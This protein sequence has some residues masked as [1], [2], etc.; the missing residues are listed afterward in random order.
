MSEPTRL[1]DK[2]RNS[3]EILQIL[4]A[5]SVPRRMTHSELDRA[6]ARVA[7]FIGGP[8]AAIGFLFWAKK[9][10][11]AAMIGIG[12]G[13]VVVAVT[14]VLRHHVDAPAT[15]APPR[16]AEVPPLPQTV[17][18][19]PAEIVA[20]YDAADSTDASS[21]PT[22]SLSRPPTR[23]L[24]AP[25]D[26]PDTTAEEAAFL[27]HARAQVG[28]DPASALALLQSHVS[29]FRKPRLVAERD[30]LIVDALRRLG[31]VR[32]ARTMA[33]SLIAAQP[34]SLYARRLRTMVGLA[35]SAEAGA[36]ADPAPASSQQPPQRTP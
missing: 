25:V 13:S 36:E 6:N 24:E 19:I 17:V 26:N 30:F 23:S 34:D 32:E 5:T 18:P 12:T 9:L 1:R 11:L 21:G 29:T 2:H 33:A 14:P 7:G 16:A 27:E 10:A 22:G 15:S 20:A 4:N 28:S 8:V 35:G 3:P 31:R